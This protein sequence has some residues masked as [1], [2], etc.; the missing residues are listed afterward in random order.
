VVALFVLSVT[1]DLI[2]KV[3]VEKGVEF[4]TGLK[5]SIGSINVGIFRTAVK[6]K[7]LKVINPPQF[8][9]RLMV[10][11]PEIYVDYDLPAF[12]RGTVHLESLRLHLKEFVVVKNANGKLN[13]NSL[14][15]VSAK[16]SGAP[17]EAG[18]KKAPDIK[19]DSLELRIDRAV[20]KDYTVSGGP[21]IIEYNVNIDERYTNITNPY[22]V[23]SII[24]VKALAGTSISNLANFDISG[25]KG[26]VAGAL[27]SAQD[28]AGKAANIA[29]LAMQSTAKNTPDAVKNT[30]E[31]VQ[32][33]AGALGSLFEGVTRSDSK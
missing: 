4:V 5:L 10:N 12:F 15:V 29:G 16:K 1:K 17:S 33:A 28:M 6:I 9:D 30:G 27:S 13:L 24:V 11:M 8:K 3:S 2:I 18:G 32:K 25:L 26:S 14:K 23:V 31:T 21:S 20:Y 22:S 19:I 7:N